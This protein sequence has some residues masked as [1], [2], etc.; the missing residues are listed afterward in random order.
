MPYFNGSKIVE[1]TNLYTDTIGFI[2]SVIDDNPQ[3]KIILM[4]DMNCDFYNGTNQFSDSLIHFINQRDLCCTFDHMTLFDSS[5]S[6]TRFDLKLNSFSIL[7]YVFISKDLVLYLRDVSILD[8]GII[9]SDHVPV[10]VNIDV[11]VVEWRSPPGLFRL[12][13][14]KRV[15]ERTNW[16]N[17]WTAFRSHI[18]YMVVIYVT[19]PLT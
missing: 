1:Q 9:L 16:R 6:Y 13:D 14:W 12:I 18:S 15:N 4:G 19:I 2:D 3:S 7:D 8:Q 5:T 10:K 11:D 17:A